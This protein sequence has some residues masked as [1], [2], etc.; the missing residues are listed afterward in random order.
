MTTIFSGSASRIRTICAFWLLAALVWPAP[1][2]A[3]GR[4]GGGPQPAAAPFF[5]LEIGWT[6]ELPAP[7]ATQPGFDDEHAYVP[8]RDGTLAAIRLHDGSIAWKVEQATALPPAADG[9]TVVVAEGAAVTALQAATGARV[10]SFD[11]GAAVST[12]PLRAAGWLIVGLEGGDL[13]AL[14]AAN[15]RELWRR[16]L[17][18]PLR[19]PPAFGGSRLFVPIDDGRLAA[20]DLLTGGLLWEQPLT[21]HPRRVLP[22]DAVFVGTTGNYLYRLSLSSGRVDWRWRT[23]GDVVGAP[24]VDEERI[25]FASLDNMLWALD[26]DSGVQ[27]WRQVLTRRPQAV[28]GL[29][30]RL[31]LVSGVSEE[32]RTFDRETGEP[33]NALTAPAE[34][35][36]P[37][38]VA[39]SLTSAGL[40]M[41][42]LAADGRLIGMRRPVPPPAVSLAEPPPPLRPAPYGVL[43]SRPL[44]IAPLTVAPAAPPGQAP[45]R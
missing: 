7:P 13:V 43:P 25:Y 6:A 44:E 30:G 26:R 33:S 37:P 11:L 34:L 38:Y 12:A 17:G 3:G 39:P 27:R 14:E 18:G 8:L 22:L 15:G 23:G 24:V 35:G 9:G 40:R 2:Q 16:A 32:V 10:W 45:A 29:L 28:P 21:G 36:A 20:L 1:S 5:P 42:V 19:I 4:G 31:L 41:V